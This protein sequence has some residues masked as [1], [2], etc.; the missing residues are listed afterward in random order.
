M[1]EDVCNFV[2]SENMT[3]EVPAEL[4]EDADDRIGQWQGKGP[5]CHSPGHCCP[6]GVSG[7]CTP[8]EHIS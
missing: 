6:A 5:V 1:G 7:Q 2:K 3:L 4:W 8:S